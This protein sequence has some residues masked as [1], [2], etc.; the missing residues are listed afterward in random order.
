M[1]DDPT[2]KLGREWLTEVEQ[3]DKSSRS[4]SWRSDQ[5]NICFEQANDFE[6]LNDNLHPTWPL[7]DGD[8]PSA[9]SLSD[10]ESNASDD[11]SIGSFTPCCGDSEGSTDPQ[12]PSLPLTTRPPRWPLP[13]PPVGLLGDPYTK[14]VPLPR[15]PSYRAPVRDSHLPRTAMAA[16]VWPCAT[17]SVPRVAPTTRLS[18]IKCAIRH[19]HRRLITI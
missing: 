1:P 12:V 14:G 10:D 19:L 18:L 4:E 16:S 8:V 17:A 3:C 13:L 5:H 7:D 6:R 9:A 2:M 11:D 15:I